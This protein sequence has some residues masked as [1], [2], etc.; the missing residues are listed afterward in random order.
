MINR[1][2]LRG[3]NISYSHQKSWPYV[4]WVASSG[5]NLCRKVWH[6]VIIS[7]PHNEPEYQIVSGR[8]NIHPVPNINQLWPPRAGMFNN[9]LVISLGTQSF[10]RG[11][12][13]RGWCD[14]NVVEWLRRLIWFALDSVHQTR[15]HQN[16]FHSKHNVKKPSDIMKN[17]S[18]W[19]HWYQ[20]Y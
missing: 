16:I 14:P 18:M 5:L 12:T 13:T 15:G 4:C 17:S 8:M 9:C 6:E 7:W 19:L 10:S 11:T 20:Q 1:I 2:G 3:W